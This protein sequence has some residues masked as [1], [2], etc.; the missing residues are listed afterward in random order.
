MP[1]NAHLGARAAPVRHV[2]TSRHFDVT[3][4]RV[5]GKSRPAASKRRCVRSLLLLT[6]GALVFKCL[7]MLST[8]LATYDA[9]IEA[10]RSGAGFEQAIAWVMQ[11][12]VVSRTLTEKLRSAIY[13]AL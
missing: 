3:R 12:D 8:G 10:L 11:P 4:T 2:Q 7:L 6:A 5:P 9:R 13:R 1:Q